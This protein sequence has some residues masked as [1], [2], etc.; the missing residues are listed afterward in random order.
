MATNRFDSTVI[1]AVPAARGTMRR[2][3]VS[4]GL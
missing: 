1:N 3:A 4:P 2:V